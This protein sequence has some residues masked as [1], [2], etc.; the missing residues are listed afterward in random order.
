[1]ACQADHDSS[2][3]KQLKAQIAV[4]SEAIE[5]LWRAIETGQSV[6]MLTER[7]T[8]RQAEKEYLENRLAIE[9]S[10]QITYTRPQ[11]EAFLYYLQKGDLNDEHKCRAMINIFLRAVYLW[12]DKFTL[13]LNGGRRPI[14][15]EDIPLDDIEA[16]N[17]E[18]ERSN[19][20]A[21]APPPTV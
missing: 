4:T 14:R 11:V 10:R 6:E 8:Q 21:T 5:N 17:Q 3:I 2:G 12:D 9:Q 1:M 15:I 7:I 18:Y 16:S 13:I 19:M 20:V